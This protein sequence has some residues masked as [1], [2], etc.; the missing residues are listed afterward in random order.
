M[1]THYYKYARAMQGSFWLLLLALLMSAAGLQ[2][3]NQLSVPAVSG[4]ADKTVY[5]PVYLDNEDEIVSAQFDVTLPFDMPEGASLMPTNR[6]DGHSV[7]SYA[8]GNRV[9]RVVLMSF[10]NKPLKGNSGLLL[11]IPMVPKDNLSTDNTDYPLVV[12]NIVLTDAKGNN[13]ASKATVET[14]FTIDRGVLPDI[15]VSSVEPITRQA[16][17]GDQVSIS[18]T[19]ANIGDGPTK[20][21]WTEKFYLES[22]RT[23]N[24]IFLGSQAHSQTLAA[25]SSYSGTATF[26]L[27]QL[28]HADGA[29][30]VVL[31]LIPAEGM[32]ELL[33]A[34]GNNE[35]RSQN[36]LNLG[37]QLSFY[38]NKTTLNEHVYRY[39][40]Y[41]TY[42]DYITL[43]LQRSGDWTL[44]EPLAVTCDVDGLLMLD[45][46][47]LY[48]SQPTIVRIPA[49]QAS[50]TMRLRAVNDQIRRTDKATITITPQ[51]ASSGYETKTLTISR[52]DDDLDPL[53]LTSSVQSITEGQLLTLTAK[54]G[55]E[56]AE[57][58]DIS[59]GCSQPGRFSGAPYVIHIGKGQTTG[60][61]TI[62]SVDDNVPQMD[63]TATFTARATGCQTAS[64]SVPLYDN[65]RP[66]ITL[67]VAPTTVCEN[68]GSQAA[69]AT[70]SRDRGFDQTVT[71]WLSSSNQNN[72]FFS[73]QQVQIPAGEKQVQVPVGVADNTAVDGTRS[74]TLTA[75]LYVAASQQ[76][77]SSTDRASSSARLTVTDDEEPYLSISPVQVARSEGSSVTF[78]LVRHV[79]SASQSQTVLLSASLPDDVSMPTS[80]T[81][82]SGQTSTS[83]TVSIKRNQ[84]E[85]DDRSLT[86]EAQADGLN[87]TQAVL[88]IT[89]RTLPDAVCTTVGTT[90]S[91]LYSGMEATLTA[92]ITNTGTAQLPAGMQ[93]DFYLADNSVLGRYT[94]ST[95]IVSVPTTEAIEIDETKTFTYTVTLPQLTGVYY[96]YARVNGDGAISEFS[97][98]N[99]VSQQ[100]FRMNIE[101]PFA[102][103]ELDTDKDNYLPND[104]IRVTGRVSSLLPNGLE[105]QQVSIA[106]SGNGQ[107]T[108]RQTVAINEYDGTFEAYLRI[109]SSATGM[110]TVSARAIGQTDAALS[111]QVNVYTIYLS[112]DVSSRT[113]SG[114]NTV[115][116]KL[117]L[118][119]NS[120]RSVSGIAISQ[121]TTLPAGCALSF[122]YNGQTLPGTLPGSLAAGSYLEIDYQLAIDES[123][124]AG[125]HTIGFVAETAE[126]ARSTTRLSLTYREPTPVI[127]V[128]PISDL[129]FVDGRLTTTLLVGSTRDLWVKIANK[130][131]KA[132]GQIEIGTS[133]GD[134]L[135]SLT[136]SPMPSVEGGK[137]GWIHLLLTHRPGMHSGQ[138]L[139]GQLSIT[140]QEGKGHVL[141]IRV[142]VVGTEWSKLDIAANDVYTLANQDY[143]H[144][145]G[146]QITISNAATGQQVMTGTIGNDG[147]W[148]TD[149]IA[150]GTYTVT[151]E[152]PRHKTQ[153]RTLVMGPDEERQMT[154]LLPYQAVIVDYVVTQSLDDASY[155]AVNNLDVDRDAPQAIVLAELP[156]EGF[157]CGHEDIDVRLTNVGIYEAT[158]VRLHLPTIEGATLSLENDAPLTLAA[159]GGTAVVR[160]HYEGGDEPQRRRII[161]KLR[162]HYGFTIDGQDLSED[163]T[164]QALMGCFEEGRIL[165]PP[166]IDDD[167]IGDD[168]GGDDGDDDGDDD[169]FYPGTKNDPEPQGPKPTVALPTKNSSFWLQFDD[170]SDVVTGEPFT[171][172]LTV[173]NGQ[174]GNF[175]YISFASMV[176]DDGDDVAADY[177]DRFTLERGELTGFT[178]EATGTLSLNGNTTGTMRLT[179]TPLPEAAADGS[180]VYYVGGLLVYSNAADGIMHTAT[181]P[182]VKITV[183]GRGELV[184]TPIV[185]RYFPGEGGTAQMATL[186]QNTALLDVDEVSLTSRQPV[187]RDLTTFEPIS[188]TTEAQS[189]SEVASGD[190]S[191]HALQSIKAGQGIT[192]RWL[193]KSEQGGRVDAFDR[194]SQ[195]LQAKAANRT[196]ITVN[197]VVEL[198]RTVKNM[199]TTELAGSE[200]DDLTEAELLAQADVMLIVENDR[201]VARPD[202]V[203]YSDGSD[204][205]AIADVSQNA[206]ITGGGQEYTLTVT[207]ENASWVYGRLHD[208]TNGKML[209]TQVVRQSDGKLMSQAN[210]WQTSRTLQS[211]LTYIE[212][213][214][215]HFA[216]QVGEEGETYTLH[217][218]QRPGSDVEPL[219]IRLF[220]ASGQ[221]V[222]SG[223]TVTER[224]VKAQIDFT[225]AIYQSLKKN[226]LQLT[227]RDA[228]W[229]SMD[230][231]TIT[232]TGTN[233]DVWELD[234]SALDEVPGPHS[235]TLLVSKVRIA[236]RDYMKG[237]DLQVSWT[238]Q[239][240]GT[241]YIDLAVAPQ[242]DFG[243]I[244]QESGEYSY[245]PHTFTATPA[246][247]YQFDYWSIDGQKQADSQP[248]LTYE[249][250][251]PASLRAHFSARRCLI[252]VEVNNE[253]W[254]ELSR[255][256][257]GTVPY[258]WGEELVLNAR[259]KQGYEFECWL[260]DGEKIADAQWSM[261]VRV[262]DDATY[263]AV[264]RKKLVPG[265]LVTDQQ[266]WI[267]QLNDDM[268]SVTLIDATQVSPLPSG[269]VVVPAATV[270][271][272]REYPVTGV[273][274]DKNDPATY[275]AFDH[276]ADMTTL[277]LESQQA[278]SLEDRAFQGCS[279]LTNIYVGYVTMKDYEEDPSLSADVEPLLTPFIE[280]AKELTTFACAV[281]IDF[282]RTEGI[283]AYAVTRYNHAERYVAMDEVGEAPAAEGLVLRSE[284]GGK[285]YLLQR[286]ATTIAPQVNMLVG[287]VEATDLTR[288]S[289]DYTNFLLSNGVFGKSDNGRLPAGKAYLPVPTSLLGDDPSGVRSISMRFDDDASAI[290]SVGTADAQ[291]D[292]WYLLDGRRLNTRPV[293]KGVYLQGGKKVTMK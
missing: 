116:G 207:S 262:T 285:R 44:A 130:G 120:G 107:G 187:V 203:L 267:Y 225:G 43:S 154:F 20:A 219:S 101:A 68:A 60:S 24:R 151:L 17:P 3:Q 100:F 84:T 204:G 109:S 32:G 182:Q 259:A 196:K 145:S 125:T 201:E 220:T 70:I 98:Q 211:D 37:K 265:D 185:Q 104:E 291:A 122:S 157:D 38:Y 142:T 210:F 83:F 248:E 289:G 102:L 47:T 174:E 15:T 224:V 112:A 213:N 284:G 92:T 176:S 269:H 264:F 260:L 63:V 54:R 247:G 96:L 246:E 18:Y 286:S 252:T 25:E 90:T 215:L 49:G 28:P 179:F 78:T 97:T 13:L 50:I 228:A 11:R 181:L 261:T 150:Q 82:G 29:Q 16:N 133:G 4:Q 216:D 279:S 200:E 191:S 230:Q 229:N 292:G 242:E 99:N 149:H 206:T 166:I 103:Q 80:V 287:A 9:Y 139:D 57:D 178:E 81:F 91:P 148:Q 277:T 268:A 62:Q 135:S 278:L 67:A 214:Q 12:S 52:V 40:S 41:Y 218:E 288:T 194:L 282:T 274:G 31:E 283:K 177:S 55:G 5:V 184:V 51:N 226:A 235:L 237:D 61:L 245:G 188:Y 180:H 19:V 134:W 65:D 254:G 115:T 236:A 271:R 53:T 85:D 73:Q 118:R 155:T 171:A 161:G 156:E 243:S 266:G 72:A 241:A 256:T 217:Y 160:I 253:E 86:I 93:I 64:V 273:G 129:Q 190:F 105:G 258:D 276:C 147:H 114:A 255:G 132:T 293:R 36:V 2:A 172:T 27:A 251:G 8:R 263:T 186:V 280:P 158:N 250:W 141:P 249:V 111:K 23:G 244:D 138:V 202:R 127:E 227:V 197:D 146:A 223:A 110:L 153:S 231:M 192:S 189:L 234:L 1:N 205:G 167:D 69:V 159:N 88:N 221:E 71:I 163:D 272:E 117:R 238:E 128:D 170:V 119:N 281:G 165:P 131:N 195:T 164:Y 222:E 290:K 232:G 140:P 169:D 35:G 126:G 106:L 136:A 209:L 152:A 76:V 108:T 137:T 74:Y 239:L 39:S 208:P 21:G 66:E 89:D 183:N 113:I 121:P 26:Q 48:S 95:H 168:D 46:T 257:L 45:G 212:E 123:M 199:N 33:S 193:Y 124:T 59:V 77:A 58:V 175:H 162:L 10:E 275:G 22:A 173:K 94:H 42:Y 240:D 270:L 198:F 56:L 79:V 14:V 87:G 75:A 144:V 30:V 34:Q 233:K 6:V 143:S 7:N